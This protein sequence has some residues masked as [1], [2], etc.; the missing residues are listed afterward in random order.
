MQTRSKGEKNAGRW[1]TQAPRI[2]VCS[3]FKG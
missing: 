1:F 2:I 3:Y